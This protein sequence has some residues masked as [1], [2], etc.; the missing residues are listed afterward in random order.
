M[1]NYL[2]DRHN[3]AVKA[4]NEKRERWN[5]GTI[6]PKFEELEYKTTLKIIL[7]HK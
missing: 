2:A 1:T 3:E 5:G 7:N 6:N 4:K